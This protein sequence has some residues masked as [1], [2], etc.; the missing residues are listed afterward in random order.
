MEDGSMPPKFVIYKTEQ[1]YLEH[2]KKHYCREKI[3]TP[4]KIRFIFSKIVSTSRADS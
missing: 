4:D 3:Y 1:E 2:Y